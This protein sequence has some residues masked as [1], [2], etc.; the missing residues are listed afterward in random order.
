LA[1]GRL[2]E[3]LPALR[4]ALDGR[5]QAH[6]RQLPDDRLDHMEYLERGIHWLAGQIADL[7]VEQEH[8]V[9]LL[10]TLPV[11][12]PMTAAAILA[13]IGADLS[14]FPSAAHL[15][16]WAGVGPG[17]N[18]SAGTQRRGA[19]TTGNPQLTTILCELAATIARCAGTD[20]HALNP[21]I[22]RRRGK[23]RAML[24]VAHSL[25]VSSY[26][27]LRDHVPDHDLGPADVDQLQ[28]HRLQRHD[29][30]RLEALGIP[31]HRTPAS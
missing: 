20:L 5:V 11:T 14:R 28:A 25:C 16:S 18:R 3:Q 12:G 9:D 21:C 26:D 19:T 22:A 1:K 24:A 27:L 17:N 10:L 2:R 4:L 23:P 15:A 30:H 7:A 29:V 6:H 13:E 31:V 8:T